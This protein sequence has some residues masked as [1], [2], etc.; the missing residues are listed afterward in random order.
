MKGIICVFSLK[1]SS[2]PEYI[3]HAPC[4]IMS[5]DFHPNHPHMIVAGLSDGNVEVYNLQKKGDKQ[6]YTSSGQRKHKDIVWQVSCET[7]HNNIH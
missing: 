2:H 3:F 6:A 1:N 5:V 4:R 7:V